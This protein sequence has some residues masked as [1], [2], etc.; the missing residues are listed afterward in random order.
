MTVGEV[1]SES[2]LFDSCLFIV[3]SFLY[4][5]QANYTPFDNTLLIFLVFLEATIFTCY[6]L[7]ATKGLIVGCWILS[8]GNELPPQPIARKGVC[9]MPLRAKKPT[10]TS[11][12]L[13][14]FLWGEAGVG[15]T[16]ACLQLP[17]PYIID[18]ERGTENYHKAINKIGG[19]VFHTTDTDDVLEEIRKLSSEKHN[20]KTLVVDSSS[21]L[22]F[23]S[24]DKMEAE[25]GNDFGKH[26]VEAGK[27][28][29]R[30]INLMMRVDMNIIITSHSKVMYG[31]EMKKV[32]D[33][34]DSWKRFD[35]IFDLVLQLKKQTP[36]KRYATV[37]KTRIDTFPDGET[38]E[39]NYDSLTE[40][41]SKEELERQADVI[42][43]ATVKQVSE[44]QKMSSK[45]A[46]G[47]KKV[48]S[49]MRKAGVTELNDL[50][51][52]QAQGVI[53]YFMKSL[54][55]E[56]VGDSK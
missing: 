45:L 27:V 40:R 9:M 53:D 30:M 16:M 34:F 49:Y 7:L 17:S 39:W 13:K 4:C 54:A 50:T 35:Y 21:P 42:T 11:K 19:V 8:H 29:K 43:T 18:T 6:N 51:C 47:K 10:A 26:Y 25:H 36:T 3:N 56:P 31:D 2:R 55:L 52:E 12:R 24:V 23:A 37:K 41:F 1:P 20:Y 44:I 5:G 15:K 28:F 38:F 22:F 33:T 48:D 14:L 32:G 46:D